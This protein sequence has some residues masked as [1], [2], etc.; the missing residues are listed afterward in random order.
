MSTDRR[1]F[2]SMLGAGASM[3][4]A[5]VGARRA[6]A[7]GA[8]RVLVVGGGTG[9]CTAAKYLK[10]E[11]PDLAVTVIEPASSLHRCWGSNEVLT[12]HYGMDA[13]TVTHDM[14][15]DRYGIDFVRENVVAGDPVARTVTLTDGRTLAYDR[16]I[17]S[18]GIQFDMGAVEG[19]DQ[20]AADGPIPHAYKA[21]EQTT[22]L[23]DQIDAMPDGGTMVIVPP[24]NPYRCPPGP[25]ERA[26]LLAQYFTFAKPNSKVLILDMKDGFTK[27]QPFML[28]WNRLYGFDIPKTKMDGM[29]DDVRTHGSPGLIEWVS[30]A[31]GGRVVAI[32]PAA[33]TLRTE[34]G[35]TVKADVI[36]YIPP[37]RANRVAFDLDLVDGDWCPIEAETM[38]SSRHPGIHV[39]GDAAMA[40][41]MPKSGYSANT[42]AKI[43]AAQIN[44][45]LAGRELIEPTWSNACFSRVSDTYGVSIA[46]QFRLDRDQNAIV[47][48]PGAGGISSLD[49]SRQINR[50][51]AFYQA[52]WMRNFVA[53]CFE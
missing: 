43:A 12:G 42:Q 25:Y 21:G 10:L 28:G 52:A 46:D 22:R 9:G 13:I 49:A 3:T 37:Q 5:P 38:E 35:E 47:A 30:G 45:L 6:F 4:I 1:Q 50:M 31:Q 19:Y 7:Q 17:V 15:R 23:R 20:A 24:P 18:P 33:M 53:D 26:S 39:L 41:A 29:P 40:G 36:N 8:P 32:D 51:E 48:T 11:N 2:L 27:D 14:L 44:R 16:M 34:S